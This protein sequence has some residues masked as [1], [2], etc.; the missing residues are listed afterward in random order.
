MADGNKYGFTYNP[1]SNGAVDQQPSELFAWQICLAHM[2]EGELED[3]TNYPDF[4]INRDRILTALGL[5]MSNGQNA[6][7]LDD[8]LFVV[9]IS[10]QV[11][12]QIQLINEENPYYRDVSLAIAEELLHGRDHGMVALFPNGKLVPF[13]PPTQD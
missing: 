7:P 12:G 13:V 2:D 5:G 4:Y 8:Q 3:A 10:V 11:D 9:A 6:L 1:G